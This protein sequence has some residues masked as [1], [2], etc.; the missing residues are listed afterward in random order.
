V[1]ARD[2]VRPGVDWRIE[3]FR[4]LAARFVDCAARGVECTPG[5]DTG[6]RAQE[7]IDL[8]RRSAAEGGKTLAAAPR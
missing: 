3:P 4:R 8:A 1:V 7:L 5:F 6:A 2:T